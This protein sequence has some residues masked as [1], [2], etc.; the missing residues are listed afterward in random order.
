MRI[1]GGQKYENVF[2]DAKILVLAVIL[3]YLMLLV[4]QI[5]VHSWEMGKK[6]PVFHVFNF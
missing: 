1:K 3:H 2:T 5:G 6:S 4:K